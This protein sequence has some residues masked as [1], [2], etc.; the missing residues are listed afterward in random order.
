MWPAFLFAFMQ[1]NND[2][3]E[4]QILFEICRFAKEEYCNIENTSPDFMKFVS[5][6]T[7]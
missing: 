5:L 3:S 6:K 7:N 2:I 4:I 1:I